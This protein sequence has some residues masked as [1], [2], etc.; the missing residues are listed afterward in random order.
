MRR[1][2]WRGLALALAVSACAPA[3]EAPRNAGVCWRMAPGMN[4]RQDF[5]PISNSVENLET[6]AGQLEG[7][8]LQQGQPVTGAF[9]GR[10]IY[11]TP[12]EIT[13]AAGPRAQRYRV[14]T[15]E[16]RA[17]IQAGYAALR[18]GG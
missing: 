2:V 10:Y 12:E 17:R 16:Q 15:P 18:K 7:L 1:R 5:R 3:L 6:C 8:R 4:G 11:V 14:F 9:Q 13:V